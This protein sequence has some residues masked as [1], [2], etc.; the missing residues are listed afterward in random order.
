VGVGTFLLV[1][2]LP[3]GDYFY[4]HERT[5]VEVLEDPGGWHVVP[6]GTFQPDSAE[7]VHHKRDFSVLRSTIRE[8]A[9]ELLGNEEL[10]SV[11]RTHDDFFHD[12]RLSP[13]LIGLR[14][15][16][17][18]AYFLGMGISPLSTK[19][20]FVTALVLDASRLPA[21]AVRF[22]N[23]F[24]G[25]FLAVPLEELVNWSVDPRMHPS[26]SACCQL[27]QRHVDFL[28]NNEHRHHLHYI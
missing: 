10:Q 28:K 26:A 15:S 16:S 12:P 14:D 19:A 3:S 25:K 6:S 11:I 2:N 7:D 21:D 9:E 5:G 20:V 18:R 1:T 27:A 4:L 24:E 13:Y 8:F 23:N 17:V 22:V